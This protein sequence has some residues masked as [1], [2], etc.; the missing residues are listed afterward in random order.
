MATIIIAEVVVVV[1]AMENTTTIIIT[2]AT[3]TKPKVFPK[4]SAPPIV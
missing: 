2:P 4:S 3:R 1:A